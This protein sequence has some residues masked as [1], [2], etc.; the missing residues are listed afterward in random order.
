MCIIVIPTH[1]H[2][3]SWNTK[4]SHFQSHCYFWFAQFLA[5]YQNLLHKVQL[6]HTNFQLC[7]WCLIMTQKMYYWHVACV[8][9]IGYYVI[10]EICSKCISLFYV[11]FRRLY[12]QGFECQKCR[13]YVKNVQFHTVFESSLIS[14]KILCEITWS[15]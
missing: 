1:Y 5:E 10:G 13:V 11:L 4:M 12:V 6:A 9:C 15:V 8:N 2:A 14:D 7:H 3:C